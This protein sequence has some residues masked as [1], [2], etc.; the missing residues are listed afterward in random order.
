[1]AKFHLSNRAVDDLSDIWLYTYSEW[2]E[3]QADK[4]Y[5]SLLSSCQEIADNQNL[6]KVYPEISNVL[7]GYKSGEH[8]IFYILIDFDEIEIVRILHGKMNLKRNFG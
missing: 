4:Y 8:I 2:S 5:S 3:G 1:M 6:G 7:F